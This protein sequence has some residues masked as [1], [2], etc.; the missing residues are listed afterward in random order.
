VT[1]SP[2]PGLGKLH[3]VGSRNA[4][5]VD[6]GDNVEY[7]EKVDGSQFNFMLSMEGR[8]HF[9]SKNAAI[10]PYSPNMFEAGVRSIEARKD[11]LRPGWVYRGEY[12]RGPKQNALQYMRAP[13][14]HVYLFRV[15]LGADYFMSTQE[16][17]H[18]AGRLGL[19]PPHI[20]PGP[21]ESMESCLGGV[22]AEG[23]VVKN[24]DRCC[25]M[26]GKYPLMAKWVRA[27]FR[28]INSKEWSEANPKPK[29]IVDQLASEV[30]TETRM[31]KAI[32]RLAEQGILDNSPRD[33]E[34]LMKELSEDIRVE[35]A[36]YV[37]E[38][39]LKH[40]LPQV[41]RKAVRQ[42]PQWYR[43]RIGYGE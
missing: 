10:N 36:E 6:D 11:L 37:A 30:C 25:P 18:E 16:L 22:V 8:L 2:I 26:T 43:Q 27:D 7:T 40:F 24:Y 9:R 32:Q 28:E 3:H 15:D 34:A 17:V 1:D 4:Q 31:E 39:L 35:A 42:F 29:D 23:Y 12:L 20:L 5:F 14:G 41:I 21:S 13:A 33:I 38:R 19:E